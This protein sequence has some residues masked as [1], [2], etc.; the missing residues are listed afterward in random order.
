MNRREFIF[1]AT[2]NQEYYFKSQEE[3]KKLFRDVPEA[4]LNIEKVVEKIDLDHCS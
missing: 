3:M 1:G 4:M 2:C